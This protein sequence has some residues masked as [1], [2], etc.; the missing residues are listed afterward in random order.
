MICDAHFHLIPFLES[1]PENL[2][3]PEGENPPFDLCA[4]FKIPQGLF[5]RACTCAHDKEEFEKQRQI[6][7]AVKD[8]PEISKS[9]SLHEAFGMHPQ[10]PLV[11]N[12]DFLESLL[13]RDLICA[14]GET[15][16]DLFNGEFK[17]TVERQK[18]AWDIQISLAEKYKKPVVIHCRKAMHLIFEDG[19]RLKKL[20]AVIFHSFPGSPVEALSFLKRGV[21]AFFSFGK[22]ILNNNKR[23]VACVSSLPL[24]NLLLE[25]DSPFQTLKGEKFTHPVEI[26]R[27]YKEAF[28]LRQAAESYSYLNFC[29]RLES[30]FISAF[31]IRPT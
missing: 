9:L 3:L 6:V 19:R 30:N 31:G 25:T 29:S 18:Q 2:H 7:K 26:L 13:Q 8:D 16:F 20:P 12:A 17:R 21:N 28:N 22:Q 4:A 1:C 27:V 10:D 24:Q 5:L 14:V 11:E 15:G 23:A